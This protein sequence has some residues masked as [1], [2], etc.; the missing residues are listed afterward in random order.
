MLGRGRSPSEAG[1]G[2]AQIIQEFIDHAKHVVFNP[3][4]MR[5]IERFKQG[6]DVAGFVFMTAALA[7]STD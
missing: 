6:C 1:R 7:W 3:K 2:Q 5:T 4:V